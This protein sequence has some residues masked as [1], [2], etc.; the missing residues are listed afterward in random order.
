ME[1][2]TLFKG[3][4]VPLSSRQFMTEIGNGAEIVRHFIKSS[5]EESINFING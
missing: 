5:K 1:R 2:N 4:I 3:S